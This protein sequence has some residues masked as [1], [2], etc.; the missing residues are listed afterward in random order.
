MASSTLDTCLDQLRQKSNNPREQGEL[1]ENLMLRYFMTDPLYKNRFKSIHK[2]SQWIK[3]QSMDD[4]NKD[5]GIDLVADEYDGTRCGI[6]CK[7][8]SGT[9]SI[10]TTDVDSFF[11]M[12]RGKNID[13]TILI[14]TG[15]NIGR[16]AQKKIALNHCQVLN[17]DA[18]RKRP[19]D[20]PA[21]VEKPNTLKT[22]KPQIPRLHQKAAIADVTK[23]F[24]TSPRG[25]LIMACGTGKTL[26]SLK[27]AEQYVGVRGGIVLY[28][29]PSISLLAQ[30]M[31]EWASN[32]DSKATPRYFAVCSDVTVG[33]NDDGSSM[34]D[35]EIPATT[36]P[37]KIATALCESSSK[38]RSLM[39]FCTYQSIDVIRQA[40]DRVHKLSFDLVLC[41]EAHRTTGIETESKESPFM[42]IHNPSYISS[43]RVLYMTATQKVYSSID[44]SRKIYSMKDSTIYGP[45]FHSLAFSTA[46]DKGILSDYRVIIIGVSQQYAAKKLAKNLS[47]INSKV[48]DTSKIIGCWKV[49]KNPGT[50]NAVDSEQSGSLLRSIAFT[51]LIADSKKFAD[52]FEKIIKKADKSA[53]C[54][55]A[56]VSGNMS[57]S[58]RQNRLSVL[59]H[60]TNDGTCQIVSNARC[61]SE[62]VDVPELD[63]VI[64]LNPKN[65][66]IDV[67]QAVGRVMRKST[68]KHFGHII[69]PIVVPDKVNPEAELDSNNEYKT[70]WKILKA[71]RSHDD[72][73]NR[74]L[75]HMELTNKI[76]RNISIIGIDRNG[77]RRSPASDSIPFGDID[78]PHDLLFAKII[79]KVGDRQYWDEWTNDIVRTADAITT[80]ITHLVDTDASIRHDFLL[81]SKNITSII[82]MQTEVTKSQIIEML[83]QHLL[84][85]PIYDALFGN[86]SDH[87]KSNNAASIIMEDMLSK[88]GSNIYAETDKLDNFYDSVRIRIEGIDTLSGKQQI[89]KDLYGMFFKKAFPNTAKRLGIV[90]TPVE[91]VDFILQSVQ[92]IM[93]DEFKHKLDDP[94]VHIWDPFT[95]TGTFI[96]RLFDRTLGILSSK[97]L[98]LK[99]Q[100]EIHANEIT[101]LG[102]HIASMNIESAYFDYTNTYA[103][104]N[105]LVFADTFQ[106]YENQNMNNFLFPEI[107]RQI[108]HQKLSHIQVIIGNPPYDMDRKIRYPRLDQSIENTYK[109]DSNVKLNRSLDDS[110]IRAIRLAT[111][112]LA[113]SN[114]IIAFVTNA[115][116]LTKATILTS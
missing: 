66:V 36:D 46:I 86:L 84:T 18:L 116:F 99:F 21:L 56:H 9:S 59:E 3:N 90:Y 106:M 71:L 5:L 77:R 92:Y 39:I 96:T 2:Y 73:L 27:I 100:S 32:Y 65:S 83:S 48:S 81:F 72:R 79:E 78:I 101:L 40:I 110:Y 34:E 109:A 15:R 60:G 105:G 67:I 31:R 114:G 28:L 10:Q 30:S 6:Q 16:D 94:G 103:I 29:V 55:A 49:L 89:L 35:L 61:L 112:R 1:F 63:A 45:L 19:I 57:S 14:N 70:V 23:G 58:D 82:N 37:I 64:F 85:K 53:M 68:K 20:W 104:F 88:F 111:D 75:A 54:H 69:L 51:N 52:N 98:P 4:H 87:G 91:I 7:F 12:C 102:H 76:P 97:A 93:R 113:S 95:G 41:D 47:K 80:R 13:N 26:V 24:Q 108:K 38:G 17:I 74:E 44:A 8:Y 107:N 115:G 11:S 33:K 62:G 42:A 22:K 25:R 50:L 43:K